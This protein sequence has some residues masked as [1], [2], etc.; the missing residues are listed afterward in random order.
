LPSP[1]PIRLQEQE[2]RRPARSHLN[3]SPRRS[4]PT[5]LASRPRQRLRRAIRFLAPA[6]AAAAGGEMN[7]G[8]AAAVASAAA[9]AAASG[10]ELLACD[11]DGLLLSRQ[12]H[13]DDEVHE[14]PAS[15]A[16]REKPSGG[17][18]NRFAPRFDGLRF[19]ETLV[20]AHR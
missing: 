1:H 14:G 20:T 4:G 16:S 13:H 11:C 8:L 17:G 9:V 18:G 6:A 7:W 5:P 10:A 15:L 19:I 2:A 12:Q 3:P